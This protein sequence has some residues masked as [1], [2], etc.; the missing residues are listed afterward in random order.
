VCLYD[1]SRLDE[2]QAALIAREHDG[3]APEL[4]ETPLARFLAVDE[5]WG[6]RISGE[7]DLSNRDLLHRTLLSRAAVRPRLQV[8]LAGLTFADVGG[9]SRLRAVAAGLPDS[10]WLLLSRVPAAV[11]RVLTLSGLHH[12]RLRLEP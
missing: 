1:A 8:D 2:D 5:P 12:E 7:V 10:G 9:L 6:L 4:A 11:R 3:L